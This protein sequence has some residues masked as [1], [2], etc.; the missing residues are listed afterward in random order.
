MTERDTNPTAPKP[1]KP[2]R[3][4]RVALVASLAV[5][6]AVAGVVAGAVWRGKD[7]RH[8]NVT[9]DLAM[10]YARAVDPSDRRSLMRAMRARL[11]ENRPSRAARRADYVTALDLVRATPFDPDALR[12]QLHDQS[13]R[14]QS[15][16]VVGQ[17]VLVRYLAALSAQDR[18]AYADRLEQE[19]SRPPRER[20]K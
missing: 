14:A 17:D 13:Q 10:V 6:L 8:A 12:R 7:P 19:L 16:V 5:N 20:R 3:W 15:R 1:A 18:A 4:M 2:G 11:D 9:R